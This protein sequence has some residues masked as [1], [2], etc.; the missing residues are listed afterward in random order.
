MKTIFA[1]VAIALTFSAHAARINQNSSWSEI[2][3]AHGY[4]A[5]FPQVRFEGGSLFKSIYGVCHFTND[6]GVAMLQGGQYE[7]C[8]KWRHTR[9]DSICEEYKTVMLETPVEYKTQTCEVW[10]GG[11]NGECRRYRTGTAKYPLSMN[12]TVYR[13][14]GRDDDNWTSVAFKKNYTVPA[15]E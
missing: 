4:H 8:V 7:R 5:D 11:E 14:S 9:E 3:R 1:L 6:N 12:V 2:I 10:G 15:C 13:T